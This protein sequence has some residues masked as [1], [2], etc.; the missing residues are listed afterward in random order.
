MIN[1]IIILDEIQSI[2]HNYWELVNQALKYLSS[3]F[4]CWIILM[5]ATE[6]LIF[7]ENIEIKSLVSN[8]SK[9][10][11]EFNRLDYV[12]DL[13]ASDFD[14]FKDLILEENTF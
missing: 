11:T 3:E 9:Y 6:P 1:S 5:T 8:K 4:N 14:D 10:F 13:E 7:K 2:P 12:F